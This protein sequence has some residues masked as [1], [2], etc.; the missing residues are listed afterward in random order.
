[1]TDFDRQLIDEARK[2][3]RWHYREIDELIPQAETPEARERLT[4][5]R[6]ELYDLVCET[7]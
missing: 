3:N 5:I 2:V 1:M 4:W 7:V 6:W